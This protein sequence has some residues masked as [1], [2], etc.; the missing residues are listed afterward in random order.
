M[1]P[2]HLA[3]VDVETTG[4]SPFRNRVI[5]IGIVRVDD[6][7]VTATYESLIN[8]EQY[9]RPEITMLTGIRTEQLENAP[10]FASLRSTIRELLIDAMFVAH[11]ARFDL[12]FIKSEFARFDESFRAK[13]L[14][15]AKLSRRLFPAAG[16]HN[17]DS[18]IDRFGFTCDIRHRALSDAKVLWDFYQMVQKS[19]DEE[20]LETVFADITK[21][22]TLPATLTPAIIDTLHESLGVYIFY[23]ENGAVLYIGKSINIRERVL[24]HFQNAHRS[25]QEAKIFQSIASI[26]AIPT[27]GELG[28]LLL[29]SQ[30]IKEQQPLLNRQLRK[31]ERMI[32]LTRTTKNGYDTV[33]RKDI[34]HIS[35]NDISQILAV[36]RTERQ[37]K[38]RLKELTKT[39]ALCPKL[40]G[41]EKSS[42]RCFNSHLD[43]C[44][45]ACTNKELPAAYNMRFTEAF[46][47]TKVRQWPFPGPI[48]VSEG[49]QAHVINHWCYIGKM[50]EYSEGI[51]THSEF[52][53]D[54]DN[55]KILS[56]F[57]LKPRAQTK[58]HVISDMK[59]TF[60]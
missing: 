23:D 4:L 58:I 5:E 53:F 48:A 46:F 28:A 11:N 8:P 21:T 51:P 50:D 30:L 55:Y 38:E 7:K 40:L 24:S 13:T 16:H 36:F 31:Q 41:L 33:K 37:M 12:S 32:V 26:D 1:L 59:S 22:V 14:C 47:K 17:L 60:F 43:L 42:G 54:Y 34:T 20:L 56:S 49:D 52:V 9:I 18:I 10:T 2:K 15:T 25:T 27:T 3:F 6:G 35:T 29:E 45:G 39:H 44:K 19:H 57:L